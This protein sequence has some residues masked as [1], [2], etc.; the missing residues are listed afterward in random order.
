METQLKFVTKEEAHKL[1]DE[2]PGN[3]VMIIQYS[4]V[5]GISDQGR[6]IRKKK[7]K[8]YVDKSSVLVLAQNNPVA[9]LNLHQKYFSDFTSYERE[10]IVKSILLPKLE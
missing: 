5:L 9:M 3:G 2:A 4:C 1:I 10:N 6:Y 8:K 7:G